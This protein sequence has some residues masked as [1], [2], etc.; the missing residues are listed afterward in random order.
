MNQK[1]NDRARLSLYNP[2]GVFHGPKIFKKL[3]LL[4]SSK[5]SE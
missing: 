1:E 2:C 4:L 5:K 3:G